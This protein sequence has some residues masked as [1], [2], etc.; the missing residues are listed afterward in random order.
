[1]TE[2][3]IPIPDPSVLTS[4]R[5]R[6]EIDALR[7]VVY[8][9][10]DAIDKATNLFQENLTRVPTDTDK[11]IQHLKELHD[12]KFTAAAQERRSITEALKLQLVDVNNSFIT[13]LESQRN[14][15]VNRLDGAVSDITNRLLASSH[16]IQLQFEERDV[17]SKA[18]ELAAQVAV[19]AALQ[20]QKEA[21]GAQ[22]ESNSAAIT[23]SES[24]TVKQ[25]DGILA[26]LSS[27]S[28]ALNDKIAVINGRLDRGE[29]KQGG[30]STTI[31]MAI[32]IIASVCAVGGIIIVFSKP[33]PTPLYYSSPAP[34]AQHSVTVK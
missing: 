19:G 34:D 20:A 23:K 6:R 4:D 11:Q 32:A 5:L 33:A 28:N 25:I 9:R 8:T 18:A 1:M 13:R 16:G 30:V 31:S 10:L 17:R 15:F 26:L 14:D 2:S 3:N 12:E 21:A 24:A 22:N 29:G 7:E 27:N